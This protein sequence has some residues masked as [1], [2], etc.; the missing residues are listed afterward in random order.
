MYLDKTDGPANNA[1]PPDLAVLSCPCRD[2]YRLDLSLLP[3]CIAFGALTPTS[4][5][6]PMLPPRRSA[7]NAKRLAFALRTEF[8]CAVGKREP[9]NQWLVDIAVSR[10][11]RQPHRRPRTA[12]TAARLSTYSSW[13]SIPHIFLPWE[14]PWERSLSVYFS[15]L[16]FISSRSKPSLC[17]PART[18]PSRVPTNPVN[19]PRSASRST[20]LHEAPLSH[21]T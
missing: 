15:G 20:R 5:S 4:S 17:E 2:G 19:R 16:L 14:N 6:R 21:D 11:R 18:A 7:F 10:R 13:R 3:T 8:C 1:D 9:H 12:T